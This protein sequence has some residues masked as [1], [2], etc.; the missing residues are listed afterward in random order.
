LLR[1]PRGS[2]EIRIDGAGANWVKTGDRIVITGWS[3]A[4]RTELATVRGRIV[5]LGDDNR[6]AEVLKL[7]LVDEE[8]LNPEP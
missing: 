8:E 6:V 4:D 3:M 7:G 5:A 2:G 1:G